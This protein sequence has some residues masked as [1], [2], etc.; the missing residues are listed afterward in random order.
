[1]HKD[2]YFKILILLSLCAVIFIYKISEGKFDD[3]KNRNEWLEENLELYK[4]KVKTF[5]NELKSYENK[6]ISIEETL[7]LYKKNYAEAYDKNEE[8]GIKCKYYESILKDYLFNLKLNEL[9]QELIKI[10]NVGAVII[11]TEIKEN[12]DL[13]SDTFELIIVRNKELI[14][15]INTLFR[16]NGKETIYTNNDFDI[17]FVGMRVLEKQDNDNDIIYKIEIDKTKAEHHIEFSKALSELLG[18]NYKKT[19]IHYEKN[20][21]SSL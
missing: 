15:L 9:K 20:Q 4:T 7:A 10:Y 14:E 6:N 21:V 12:M 19:K 3:L 16:Y 17:R 18:I 2:N 5:E 11:N 8:M 13:S 1:M